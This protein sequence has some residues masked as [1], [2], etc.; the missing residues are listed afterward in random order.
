MKAVYNALKYGYNISY[1]S[2][3]TAVG[4]PDGYYLQRINP[5]DESIHLETA[6]CADGAVLIASALEAIG[7]R[8]YIVTFPDHVFVAWSTDDSG[9]Y[10]DAL[11]TTLIGTAEFEDAYTV[12]NQEL[13][14]NWEAI[15]NTAFE[16]GYLIVDIGEVRELGVLPLR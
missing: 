11:E 10:I 8:P 5:P 7:I 1:V 13:R 9:T 14:E 6:N 2:T 3:A 16:D 4:G 15:N 12:G